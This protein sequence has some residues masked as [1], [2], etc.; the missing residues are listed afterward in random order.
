MRYMNT[1]RIMKNENAI[2]NKF[3]EKIKPLT[4]NPG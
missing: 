2:R 1:L 4:F 3:S